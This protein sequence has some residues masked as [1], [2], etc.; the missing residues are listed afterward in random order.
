MLILLTQLFSNCDFFERDLLVSIDGEKLYESDFE[1]YA[2]AFDLPLNDEKI[3]KDFIN[4]WTEQILINSEIKNTQPNKYLKNKY[5][6][7]QSLASLNM[8]DLENEYINSR[9]D[10]S[11]SESEILTYYEEN[12]SNYL[13]DS[14]I[15][16]GLYIKVPDTL[17]QLEVIKEAFLLKNDKDYEVIEKYANLYGTNFYWE[18]KK[19]IYVD[20]LLRDVPLTKENKEKIV[21]S[22][23]H[24]IFNDHKYVYLIN[25][26]DFRSKKNSAPLDIERDKIKKHILKRRIN[27]LRLDAKEQI[28]KNIYEKHSINRY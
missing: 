20:D 7:N 8:F 16:K 26:F 4:M 28:L 23:G 24:G 9:I 19:W 2:R 17:P 11:I 12:K 25:I 10:S 14:Y 22:K 21:L 13:Q 18:K 1:D 6:A 3:K 5:R 15:V 27:N